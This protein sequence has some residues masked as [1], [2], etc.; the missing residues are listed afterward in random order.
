MILLK[1]SDLQTPSKRK[2]VNDVLDFSSIEKGVLEIKRELFAT[3]DLLKSSAVDARKSAADKGLEFRCESAAGVPGQIYGDERR[4]RQVLINLLVNAVKFTERGSVVL[5]VAR[6]SGG[7]PAF[8]DFS[9]T[10]TGIGISSETIGRLFQPFVQAE[11][12]MHRRF[13]GTGLGLAISKRIAE[14]MGAS[15]AVESA[16]GKGSTFRFRLPLE[17]APSL[18]GSIL[19]NPP[20]RRAPAL[21]PGALALVVEDNS[22]SRTLVGV[23]LRNLGCRAEFSADGAE[24]VKA[25]APGKFSAILMDVSMPVMDG[26]EATKK[27]REIEAAAGAGH[28]PILAMTANVMSGDRE[29]C[30]ASGMDGFLAKPFKLQDLSDK[31]AP[32]LRTGEETIFLQ[33]SGS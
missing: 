5:H 21:H 15:L 16:P 2:C 32:F 25:F 8:L 24:A 29:R 17:P 20:N 12:T 30:L 19:P 1:W 33:A 14:A 31:L 22:D 13:E 10:D 11:T 18:S 28:V 27:I 4:I 9:V 3:A 26:L 23:M 7:G 6:S